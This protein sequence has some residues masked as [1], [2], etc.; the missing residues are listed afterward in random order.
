[1]KKLIP[2]TRVRIHRKMMIIGGRLGT[3]VRARH[4]VERRFV[5]VKLLRP[6]GGYLDQR[7]E[8]WLVD[9]TMVKFSPRRKKI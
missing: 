8:A 7:K 5:A 1:M 6:L 9:R 2:G 4:L 3:I